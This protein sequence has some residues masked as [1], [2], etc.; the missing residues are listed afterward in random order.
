MHGA[1][2]QTKTPLEKV[3]KELHFP[4]AWRA[5]SDQE[6]WLQPAWSQEVHW[7]CRVWR[8]GQVSEVANTCTHQHSLFI[9]KHCQN[10]ADS[11]ITFHNLSKAPFKIA[12]YECHSADDQSPCDPPHS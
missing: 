7:R 1:Q 2:S 4:P 9:A 5:E 8:D 11:L 10:Q 6:F 12:N 3:E